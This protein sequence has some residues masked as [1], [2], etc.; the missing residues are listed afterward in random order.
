LSLPVG[1][2]WSNGGQP[3]SCIASAAEGVPQGTD[4]VVIQWNVARR[5]GSSSNGHETRNSMDF[6][7]IEAIYET[8]QI[9]HE[10]G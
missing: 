2:D 8:A 6:H 3:G 10:I 9:A 1:L 4:R 5:A 7:A